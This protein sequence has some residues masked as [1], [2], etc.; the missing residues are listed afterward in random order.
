MQRHTILTRVKIVMDLA[1]SW[2]GPR[3]VD[4]V[5]ICSA[6]DEAAYRIPCAIS[7]E[8]KPR[9]VAWENVDAVFLHLIVKQMGC[10]P[11]TNLHSDQKAM[12]SS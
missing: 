9:K 5:E 6:T 7:C 4:L 12:G 10:L 1:T 8:T 2:R 11:Q 3:C